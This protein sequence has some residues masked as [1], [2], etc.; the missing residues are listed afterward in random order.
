MKEI[1][2]T[3]E[4]YTIYEADNQAGGKTYYSDSI[5]GGVML[6]DTCLHSVGELELILQIVKQGE[7]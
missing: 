6:F 4:G 7:L 3:K 5:G 2:C 1:C